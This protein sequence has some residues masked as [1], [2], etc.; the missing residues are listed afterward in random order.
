MCSGEHTDTGTGTGSMEAYANHLDTVETHLLQEIA[1]RSAHF[2][3]AAGVVQDLR[4]VLTRT[5]Q[6]VAELR[7]EV[8]C[9]ACLLPV[10]ASCCA[11]ARGFTSQRAAHALPPESAAVT[12]GLHSCA[13]WLCAAV[14]SA[15]ALSLHA[16]GLLVVLPEALLSSLSLLTPNEATA[17]RMTRCMLLRCRYRR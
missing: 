13:C 6:Q 2:F 11:T 17:V 9:P 14:I 4:M 15:E 16:D 7:R 5:F 10:L 8:R 3:E 1:A 12:A